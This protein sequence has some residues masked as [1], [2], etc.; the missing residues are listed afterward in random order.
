M[1]TA[2]AVVCGVNPLIAVVLVVEGIGVVAKG[3]VGARLPI[4]IVMLLPEFPVRNG[5]S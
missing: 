5:K 2:I 3:L 1:G 4:K